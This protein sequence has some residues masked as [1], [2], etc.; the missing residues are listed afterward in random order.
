M[1][2]IDRALLNVE[3]DIIILELSLMVHLIVPLRLVLGL[4]IAK[5]KQQLVHGGLSKG[6]VR[7]KELYKLLATVF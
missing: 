2:L 4:K 1:I 6:N 7:I 3:F 5:W